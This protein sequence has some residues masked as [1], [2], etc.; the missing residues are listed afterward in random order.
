[1]KYSIIIPAYN[2][3]E[4][5]ANA[6]NAVKAQNIPRKDFEIVVADNVSTDNTYELAL[7]SG[8]DVV[9]KE[10]K[11]G[12]NLARQAGFQNSQGEIAVFLDADCIPPPDWLERI[13]KDFSQTNIAAVSGI[14]DYQFKGIYKIINY[15]YTKYIAPP[16]PRIL[17]FIF[18]KKAGI[19]IGGNFAA[20]RE[21][22][23]AIGGLPPLVFWG[24]D[25]TTAMLISR[26]AGKVVFD[27]NLIIKSSGRRFQEHGFFRLGF[28]YIF[29]YLKAYFNA[30]SFIKK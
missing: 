13:E 4:T 1:M 25:S 23:E 6:I 17:E 18:G 5:I 9:I 22:I 8:A 15:L 27:L 7:K 14:Y 2:E 29:E 26:K 21:A 24:D 11:K 12:A 16:A 19:I 10:S 20:K 28:R 3:A 30:D